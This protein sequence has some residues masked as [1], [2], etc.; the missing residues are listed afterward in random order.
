[1][2]KVGP[3]ERAEPAWEAV[4]DLLRFERTANKSEVFLCFTFVFS[5][6]GAAPSD[7][8][9]PS[10]RTGV[11]TTVRTAVMAGLVFFNKSFRKK[12]C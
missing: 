1:M 6:I 11:S 4:T 10:H 3:E 12:L 8:P 9:T 2:N 5:L 7:Q